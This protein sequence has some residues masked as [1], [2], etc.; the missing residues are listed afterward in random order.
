MKSLIWEK[1][2]VGR[3][4]HETLPVLRKLHRGLNRFDRHNEARLKLITDDSQYATEL[5]D[6]GRALSKKLA[7]IALSCAKDFHTKATDIP[8]GPDFHEFL[9]AARKLDLVVWTLDTAAEA[10]SSEVE[11]ERSLTANF[12]V[13]SCQF[14]IREIIEQY[15]IEF[16][17]ADMVGEF[18]TET[19]A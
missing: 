7:A 11:G 1:E 17:Q 18:E 2:R 16:D 15:E 10:V 3:A 4:P 13:E 8:G 9:T 12:A 6:E 19:V 5:T 14:V